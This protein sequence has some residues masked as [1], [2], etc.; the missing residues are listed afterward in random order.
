[1]RLRAA[2]ALLAPIALTACG[3]LPHPFEDTKLAPHAPMLAMAD[4]FGVVVEPVHGAPDAAD[5][6]L[7]D[8]MALALQGAEIPASTSAGNARSYHLVGTVTPA[9]GAVTDWDI[10]WSMRDAAGTEI[11]ADVQRV[12]LPPGIE[13]DPAVLAG[14][15]RAEAPKLA[16]LIQDQAPVE[17]AGTRHLQI[18]SI[19]GAPGDGATSLKRALTFLLKRNGAALTEDG[20]TPDTVAITC[21]VETKRA[22]NDQD[23]I[24]ILWHVLKPDGSEVG[25]VTQENDVPR[26][27]I[28]GHWGDIAMAVA[29]AAAPDILRVA[30]TVPQG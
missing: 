16:A 9:P 27:V 21:T 14:P 1:M 7:A 26:A 17:H 2:L 29:D 3:E 18:R 11:G 30:S 20:K 24:K 8:T 6:V 15:M 23:H 19:D 5:K 22:A 28:E 13:P 10:R 25:V 12:S 4:A